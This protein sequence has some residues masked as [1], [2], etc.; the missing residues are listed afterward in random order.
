[1]EQSP[2]EANKLVKK[3]SRYGTQYFITIFTTAKYS[4]LSWAT[5]IQFTLFTTIP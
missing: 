4:S 1:M 3:I 2:L 5:I